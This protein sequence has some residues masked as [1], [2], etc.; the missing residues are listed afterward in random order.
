KSCEKDCQNGIAD[1][2]ANSWS[3]EVKTIYGNF[4]TN[5]LEHLC[6]GISYTKVSNDSTVVDN[7][8]KNVYSSVSDKIDSFMK[9]FI[10]GMSGIIK[11]AIFKED[12]KMIGDCNN[13]Y[14]VTQPPVGVNW[15]Y[16][17]CVKMDYVCGNPPSICHFL[18]INKEKCFKDLKANVT[19]CSK[20]GGVY[21]TMI[22]DTV[23]KIASNYSLTKDNSDYFV[24]RVLKKCSKLLKSFR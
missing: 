16:D 11:N 21:I 6:Y 22:N 7:L 3:D 4:K 15:T 1:A 2:F 20:V 10:S 18:D 13:P 17:D 9:T 12:P 24:G 8:T 23:T 5:A 14:R 19:E